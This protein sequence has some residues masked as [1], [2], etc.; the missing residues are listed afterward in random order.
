[1]KKLFERA[2]LYLH[3]WNWRDAAALKFCMCALGVLAGL[4]IPAR[5]KKLAAVLA[6]LVFAAAYVPLMVKFLPFVQ[7]GEDTE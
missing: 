1:M 6:A 4:M 2:D 5:R 3:S 7:K